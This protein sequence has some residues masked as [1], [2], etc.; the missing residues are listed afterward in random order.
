MLFFY[1]GAFKLAMCNVLLPPKSPILRSF[2]IHGVQETHLNPFNT[3]HKILNY[4]DLPFSIV[5]EN[6]S[7]FSAAVHNTDQF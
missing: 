3:L 2:D 4:K 5:N 6:I 1:E 7:C